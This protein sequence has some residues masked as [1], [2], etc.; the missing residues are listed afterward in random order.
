M[1]CWCRLTVVTTLN[2]A[3][4]SF[5]TMGS[6]PQC[7]VN[8]AAFLS[9]WISAFGV[10]RRGEPDT[11]HGEDLDAVYGQETDTSHG[12]ERS[13]DQLMHATLVA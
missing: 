6:R 7:T 3:P 11:V 4:T 2:D 9:G 8:N 13:R 1:Q 12:Q 5:N 10:W